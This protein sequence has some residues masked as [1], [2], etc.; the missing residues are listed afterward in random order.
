MLFSDFESDTWGDDWSAGAGAS[1][2]SL[3]SSEAGFEPLQGQALR[4]VVRAGTND[5]MSV[6][7]RFQEELGAEGAR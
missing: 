2:L 3:V 5:G 1:T 6:R 7:Y 4:V